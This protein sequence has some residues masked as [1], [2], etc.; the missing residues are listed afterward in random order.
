MLLWE[1]GAQKLPYENMEMEKIITHVMDK[2]RESFKEFNKGLG[3]ANN[4]SIIKGFTRIIES[5]E[6]IY[7]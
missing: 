2:K 3:T 4:E 5:G 6:Y 7:C 1:L